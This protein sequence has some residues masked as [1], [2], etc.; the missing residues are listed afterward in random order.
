ML[1]AV[2][3]SY[4]NQ[5]LAYLKVDF[6]AL[7]SQK[8]G[9]VFNFL[10]QVWIW[11]WHS[12]NP[13]RICQI[14]LIPWVLLIQR[15]LLMWASMSCCLLSY[16]IGVKLKKVF[17]LS[18]SGYY[19]TYGAASYTLKKLDKDKTFESGTLLNWG[20]GHDVILANGCSDFLW[21]LN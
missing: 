8:Q 21:H 5:E 10:S 2:R 20:G 3:H 9:M 1:W 19:R 7:L 14:K 15:E 6:I 12:P 11:M 17:W 4:F 16:V 18:R 13:A